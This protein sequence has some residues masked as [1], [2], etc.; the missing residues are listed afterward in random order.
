MKPYKVLCCRFLFA[1]L[2]LTVQ[3]TQLGSLSTSVFET[4]TAT[5][6]ELISLLTCPRTATFILL[7]FFSPLKISGRKIWEKLR[8]KHAKCSKLGRFATVRVVGS[9]GF[10]ATNTDQKPPIT[11][12]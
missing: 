6:S 1:F 7:S 2:A 8:S 9:I 3:K 5:G 11:A 12:N 10:S 4:R